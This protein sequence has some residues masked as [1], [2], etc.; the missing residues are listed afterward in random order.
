MS[1]LEVIKIDECNATTEKIVDKHRFYH[2]K[3][4]LATVEM[5]YTDHTGDTATK[6]AHQ[7]HHDA[8]HKPKE[9]HWSL[10][11]KYNKNGKLM[12]IECGHE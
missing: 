5:A 2:F 3:C 4:G 7:V 6:K 12:K 11:T 10:K 9:E 1:L 8:K